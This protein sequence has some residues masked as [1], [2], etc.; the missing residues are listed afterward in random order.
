MAAQLPIKFQEHLQVRVESR[1][2]FVSP[3]VMKEKMASLLLW[4][5]TTDAVSLEGT[6]DMSTLVNCLLLLYL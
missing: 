6:Q 5:L 2:S 4:A 3:V 1:D